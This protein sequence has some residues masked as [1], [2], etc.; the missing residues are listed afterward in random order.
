[1]QGKVKFFNSKKGYGFVQVEG[2]KN[3]LFV[4][5]SAI[6]GEGRRD[7]NEGDVVSFEVV[8]GI[9]GEQADKVVKIN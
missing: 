8:E 6:V 3:D 5:Y 9:R 2:R 7:L 1:M 4:H